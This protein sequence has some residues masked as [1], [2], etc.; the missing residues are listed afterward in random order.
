MFRIRVRAAMASVDLEV[1]EA[2][3]LSLLARYKGN[4]IKSLNILRLNSGLVTA[5]VIGQDSDMK[6]MGHLKK[7]ISANGEG[8]RR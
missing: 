5:V 8:A 1:V 6:S 2:Q 4:A 7:R 3:N